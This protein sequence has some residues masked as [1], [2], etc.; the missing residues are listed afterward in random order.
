MFHNI[1]NSERRARDCATVTNPRTNEAIWEVPVANETDLNDAV[2]AA[3][4]SF[5]SW[6]LLSVETRQRY[7]L[8]LADE[9]ERRRGE[10]H[11]PLAAETGKSVTKSSLHISIGTIANKYLRTSSQIWR[12]MIL[13]RSSDT[14]VLHIYI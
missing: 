11:T 4:V 6:K 3:R 7:L 2:K 8:N 9:L 5:E 14:M 12:L 10:I 1:I 13:W